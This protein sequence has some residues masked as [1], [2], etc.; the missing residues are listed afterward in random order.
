M[1]RKIANMDE[2][3]EIGKDKANH[4]EAKTNIRGKTCRS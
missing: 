2:I 4:K 3:E 1:R